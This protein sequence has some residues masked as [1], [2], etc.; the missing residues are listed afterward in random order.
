MKSDSC[1]I[2]EM[3]AWELS[4]QIH[5][6]KVSC[7]EVMTAYLDQIDRVNPKVN[8]IVALQERDGLMKQ[9]AE[10]DKAL[11]SGRDDGWMHGFP[12]AIKDL[13]ET[14]G[15]VT[16]YACRIFK[17]FVPPA[18]SLMVAR[19]KKAGSIIVGKTNTPEWGFGSQTYNEVYGATA[20]PYNT[21]LSSGGSSGGA[22]C[23]LAMRMQA[24]ADG[25]DFMGS[26]RNPAGWCN[27]YGYRPSWGRI[28]SPGLELFMNTFAVRGPMGRTVADLALLLGTLSGYD[29]EAPASLGKDANLDALTPYNVHERLRTCVRGR[30][31][32]WLGNWDGYLPM[33]DGVLSVCEKALEAFSSLGVAVEKIKPPYD[34]AVFWK[35][36]WLPM[37]H[38]G[39]QSL[40]IFYDDP[41][42]RKLLKPEAIFEYE[43]GANYS[44]SDMYIAAGKRSDWYRAVLNV[45]KTYDYIAVPTAQVFAYDKAVHWPKEIAGK[46]MDTYHRWMEVVT[47]WTMTGC[48]VAAI[49]AGF[50]DRGLSMGLQ[51][52]GRPRGDFD[53]LQFAYAYE[54]QN[55]WVNARRPKILD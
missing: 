6:K 31:I 30:K 23:S 43:G 11:R 44:A 39:S 17:D 5:E 29:P 52:I 54:T 28:P 12:Q 8:A 4:R 40:K 36:I 49:P 55:D 42:K 34:P 21:D 26:L 2:V 16:T 47:H 25:S 32:A 20:N 35:E 19:M 14:Q 22:A 24:V 9:A 46:K 10:K 18:D 37:R 33:E 51:I 27:V 1:P 38:F 48:P 13:E 7:S 53:L 15:I 3:P 45:F 41:E 50:N